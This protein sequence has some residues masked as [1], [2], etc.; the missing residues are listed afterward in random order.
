[1]H[2]GPGNWN[3]SVVQARFLENNSHHKKLVR[4]QLIGKCVTHLNGQLVFSTWE[5]L[6]F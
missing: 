1:M 3:V 6:N 4:Q 5:I 2:S